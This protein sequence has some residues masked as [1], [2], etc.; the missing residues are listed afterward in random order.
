MAGH[1]M[2]PVTY[3]VIGDPDYVRNAVTHENAA[4]RLSEVRR[5]AD[6]K[7]GKVEVEMVCW[8]DTPPAIP[9]YH[10]STAPALGLAP[11]YQGVKGAA[12]ATLATGGLAAAA[13]IAL[14][15]AIR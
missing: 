15:E 5:I 2:K 8:D 13:L 6:Y 3:R 11:W 12:V 10:P 1:A 4:G 9:S 14:V 7:D